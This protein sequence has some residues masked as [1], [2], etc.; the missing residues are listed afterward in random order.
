MRA[1]EFAK[2]LGKA[3]AE[4]DEFHHY[5]QAKQALDEHEAAR[6]MLDDFRKKQLEYERKKLSGEKL[7]E[8]HEQELRKL[9]AIVGLNP[10]VREYL[11]AE[12]QFSN[13]MMEVQKIIGE[14]VG[15]KM[16]EL[17][18]GPAGE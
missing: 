6:V 9:S 1:I 3:L 15:L 5:Q 12:L 4:S 13:L 17:E 18:Q 8:P 14:A 10:Y 7:L 16:P 2:Q 11:M